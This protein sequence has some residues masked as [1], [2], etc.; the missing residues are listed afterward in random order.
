MSAEIIQ[1]LSQSLL[2]GD[3]ENAGSLASQAVDQGPEAQACIKQAWAM[4]IRNLGSWVAGGEDLLSEL[5]K[6]ADGVETAI[7]ILEPVQ[8]GLNRNLIGTLFTRDLT[9]TQNIPHLQRLSQ[10]GV[11]LENRS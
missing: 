10:S 4:G 3:I 8:T 1:Q 2:V 9:A 7:Y 11:S 5:I 6:N